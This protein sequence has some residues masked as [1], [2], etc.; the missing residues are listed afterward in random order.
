MTLQCQVQGC[1]PLL[2]LGIDAAAS[3][4]QQ[5]HQPHVGLLHGQVQCRLEL[6]VSNIHITAALGVGVGTG[7]AQ[8]RLV[9]PD[10]PSQGWPG[11]CVCTS[12]MR[13]WATS[14]WLLRAARCNAVKP[15]SFLA[16]TSC[17]ARA[18]ILLTALLGQGDVPGVM[19]IP[20][21]A[22][23]GG[24]SLAT[25]HVPTPNSQRVA[26]ERRMVQQGEALA[27]GGSDID[28]WHLGEDLHNAAG[29]ST[30]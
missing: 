20:G 17:R 27:V 9:G 8:G 7:S 16:S 4:H 29:T 25:G 5:R 12:R 11:P 6:T 28:G 19:G 18:R 13:I 2:V 24:R 10:S 23:Q 22:Q 26:L 3:V 15:S 14:R 21:V 30:H 1:V